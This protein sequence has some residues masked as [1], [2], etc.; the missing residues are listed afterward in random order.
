M[1]RHSPTQTHDPPKWRPGQPVTVTPAD[2]RCLP[3]S[4]W[5]Q[6]VIDVGDTYVA[7]LLTEEKVC[8]E[9]GARAMVQP[10]RKEDQVV[11]FVGRHEARVEMANG[12]PFHPGQNSFC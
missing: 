2:S 5:V 9:R 11:P 6:D 12:L 4:T 3:Y 10:W 7:R 8:C 1:S